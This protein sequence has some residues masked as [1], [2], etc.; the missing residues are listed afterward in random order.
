MASRSP[1]LR[2]AV[3]DGETGILVPHGNV[4]VLSD[5]LEFLLKADEKRKAMGTAA[6]LFAERFTWEASAR[7]MEAF[8]LDRVA[9][10]RPQR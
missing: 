7:K 3:L 5:T 10:R 9:A 6:R 8:L 1:G 4:E 2:D